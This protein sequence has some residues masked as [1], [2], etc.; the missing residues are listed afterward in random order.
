MKYTKKK[1]PT[2]R[3][4]RISEAIRHAL[5]WIFKQDILYDPAIFGRS[6][7]VTEVRLSVDLKSARVFVIPL[8]GEGSD[9]LVL[10]LN[11]AAPF[12]LHKI[13]SRLR[14]KTLPKL[15]FVLDSSFDQ[16]R[17]IEELLGNIEASGAII[18]NER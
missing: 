4:L 10:A 18:D 17:H 16:A 8:G 3:Q 12:L 5:S 7:T 9:S 1:E 6:L 15:N 2:Q 14:L 13:S 11:R